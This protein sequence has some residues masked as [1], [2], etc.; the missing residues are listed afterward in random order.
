LTALT[1]AARPVTK[2]PAFILVALLAAGAA[3]GALVYSLGDREN[4]D[5]DTIE[6]AKKRPPPGKV[7]IK[8]G[9]VKQP[10][11]SA[12]P[13]KPIAKAPSK[14]TSKVAATKKS[15]PK[16]KPRKPPQKME[17]TRHGRKRVTKKPPKSSKTK[18]KTATLADKPVPKKAK[19]SGMLSLNTIPW[20]KVTIDGRP[21]GTTPIQGLE[22]PAGKHVIMLSN[23][24]RKLER[25]LTIELKDGQKL[26]R[27]V[28]LRR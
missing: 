8:P 17:P 7:S 18:T 27:V 14:P 3:G 26:K 23:P 15:P 19:G 12:K 5:R 20:A 11:A 6:L 28:D 21:R 10:V 1:P 24:D 25:T 4:K 13:K 16:A 9:A 2:R 22:L